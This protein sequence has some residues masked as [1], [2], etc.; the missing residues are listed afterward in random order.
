MAAAITAFV[1][2]TAYILISIFKPTGILHIICAG[3]VYS[4][5]AVAFCLLFG[6]LYKNVS[7]PILMRLLREFNVWVISYRQF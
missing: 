4:A 6:L 3:I 7:Y 1:E 2:I 5:A